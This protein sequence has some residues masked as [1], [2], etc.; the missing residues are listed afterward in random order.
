MSKV[1]I[2][3]IE[4]AIGTNFAQRLQRLGHE[5]L[6]FT[7]RVELIPFLHALNFQYY[8]GDPLQPASLLPALSQCQLLY[9]FP[10][11]DSFETQQKARVLH[12]LEAQITYH[13]SPSQS[14]NRSKLE[15][16][17]KVAS[18]SKQDLS[19]KYR[20]YAF[21]TFRQRL[22]SFQGTQSWIHNYFL[23]KKDDT[24]QPTLI[25]PWAEKAVL[26]RAQKFEAMTK[27]R[28]HHRWAHAIVDTIRQYNL[29]IPRTFWV[30][31][32]DFSLHPPVIHINHKH[33]T[34]FESNPLELSQHYYQQELEDCLYVQQ[35][36][37][38]HVVAH[39]TLYGVSC[40]ASQFWPIWT[41]RALSRN[42]EIHPNDHYFTS[43]FLHVEDAVSALL[44][45]VHKVTDDLWIY[46]GGDHVKHHIFVDTVLAL[47]QEKPALILHLLELVDSKSSWPNK[48]VSSTWKQR[49]MRSIN[50]S[51]S[52]TLDFDLIYQDLPQ[53][54]IVEHSI[55]KN[56]GYVWLNYAQGIES[57]FDHLIRSDYK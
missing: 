52:N 41:Q 16:T 50:R 11:C 6:V 20:S 23:K 51:H 57:M 22:M 53:T 40:L 27:T 54:M 8:L 35:N 42:L 56:F 39:A 2:L 24:I 36:L 33:E 47:R 5:V 7:H 1:L 48:F 55:L 12:D 25:D 26:N 37:K 4:Q 34:M 44:L 49:V 28:S 30:I 9:V 19:S 32:A 18:K 29:I 31:P 43:S 10:T 13:S 15:S 17:S 46:L 21:K 14:I 45:L 3:G 38:A